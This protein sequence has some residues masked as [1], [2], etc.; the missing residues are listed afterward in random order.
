MSFSSNFYV[1]FIESSACDYSLTIFSLVM[2][3]V[4]ARHMRR[5]SVRESKNWTR[6]WSGP[7]RT[8]PVQSSP[9]RSGL[10][11][12]GSFDTDTFVDSNL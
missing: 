7:D 6:T 5:R 10:V 11:Q 8:R 1:Y 3:C 12:P 4:C 9:V 2:C